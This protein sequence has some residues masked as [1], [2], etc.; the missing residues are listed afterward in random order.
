MI[1]RGK[2]CVCTGTFVL[3]ANI[4]YHGRSLAER[5]PG[6]Q[7]NNRAEMYVSKNALPCKFRLNKY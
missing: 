2:S 5:L 6:D 1:M 7:T 3:R 4:F